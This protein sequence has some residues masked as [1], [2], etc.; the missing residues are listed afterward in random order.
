VKAPISS[1]KECINQ[2]ERNIKCVNNGK[3][4]NEVLLTDVS[5]TKNSAQGLGEGL[6]VFKN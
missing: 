5:V 4:L 6:P 2:S 1:L 3:R